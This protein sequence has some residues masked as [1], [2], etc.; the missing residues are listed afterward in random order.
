MKIYSAVL[1]LWNSGKQHSAVP[2][3][4]EFYLCFQTN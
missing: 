3:S 1:A 2:L 4:A